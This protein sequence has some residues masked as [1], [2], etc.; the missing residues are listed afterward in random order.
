MP[1]V[2]I[3]RLHVRSWRYVPGFFWYAFLV[4]RQARATPGNISAEPLRET[5]N[6][7][8][9][10]SVWIDQKAMHAFMVSGAH[11]KVMPHLLDWCD[12]ACVAHW[13][14]DSTT[15]PTWQEVHRRMQQEGRRSKVKYPS[16]AQ[17]RFEIPAPRVPAGT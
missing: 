6:T 2:S 14:Q 15:P 16:E 8:W 1:H 13:L 3:T 12:E 10:R 17:Q 7:F 4:T 11:L 9:T 5:H